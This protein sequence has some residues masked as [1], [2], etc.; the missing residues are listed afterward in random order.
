[1]R[2]KKGRERKGKKEEFMGIKLKQGIYIKRGGNSTPSPTWKFGFTQEGPI[3]TLSARK[4]GAK[5]RQIQPLLHNM[6][7]GGHRLRH[8]HHHH[9]KEEGF[10]L[11]DNQLTDPPHSPTEQVLPLDPL[12]IS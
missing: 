12:Y 10:E 6:S 2:E 1:M 7:H 8:H 4:L 5:L 3:T 11:P 9:Q